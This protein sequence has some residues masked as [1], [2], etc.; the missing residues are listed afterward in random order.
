ML[1]A[2]LLAAEVVAP[3]LLVAALSHPVACFVLL[4]ATALALAG[5]H[6]GLQ[7]VNHLGVSISQ[8]LKGLPE[9]VRFVAVAGI[10]L[11][12]LD[13]LACLGGTV[14]DTDDCAADFGIRQAGR[15]AP[16]YG[17]DL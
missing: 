9:R 17:L 2:V 15:H 14:H 16:C 4:F 5:R 1:I 8:V 11:V 6:D 7:L 13:A 3:A 12:D 10:L